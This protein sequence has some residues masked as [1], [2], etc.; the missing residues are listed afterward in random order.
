MKFTLFEDEVFEVTDPEAL[1][2]AY[3]FQSDFYSK[4][5][6]K[7][8]RDDSSFKFVGLIGARMK[9]SSLDK[10]TEEIVR[11]KNIDIFC[12]DI[13]TFLFRKTLGEKQNLVSELNT[14]IVKLDKIPCVGFSKITKILHTRY[15][16]II[17][18]ID[19]PLQKKYKGLKQEKWK[20]GDWRQLLLDYY[21]NFLK[22]E[23]FSNV[24]KVHDKL[25]IPN[26]TKV[27]IFDILWWSY[28]KSEKN[29]VW[30]TIYKV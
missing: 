28:L 26:L 27:R 8:P 19:N 9:N 12:L 17:P 22:G 24:T 6:Q 4:Y 5:D 21:N 13:D 3:C 11:H 1:I 15:P 30:K 20:E 2:E 10:C 14:L 16:E 18:M 7:R 23:T 25:S 29:P